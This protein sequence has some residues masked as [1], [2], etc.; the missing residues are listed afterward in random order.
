MDWLS[1]FVGFDMVMLSCLQAF[2]ALKHWS[3]NIKIV[4]FGL[5]S[6]DKRYYIDMLII[7]ITIKLNQINMDVCFFQK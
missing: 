1:T 4:A 3:I 7:K 2:L 6:E 5:F